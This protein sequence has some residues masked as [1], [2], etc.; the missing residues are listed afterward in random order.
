MDTIPEDCIVLEIRGEF[1]HFRKPSTTSPAQT[2][3]IPPRTTI[4]GMLAG[5]M[6]MERHSYYELFNRENSSIAVSLETSLRRLSLGIN[7][8]T[9]EG[10]SRSL[11][12]GRPGIHITDS[13]QQ[14]VFEVVCDPIY[15]V[16]VSLE[17]ETV[18]DRM[19]TLLSSGKSVYT[20]SLGLS[21]HL[22]TYE[23]IGRFDVTKESGSASIRSAVPG[24][25]IDL[26]PSPE[27]RY[28]TERSPAFLKMREE[29][30]RQAD[31][32]QTLTYDRNGGPLALRD[33][34]YA[35]INEDCVI[36]S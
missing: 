27:A 2:F 30:G 32:S 7:I 36:F 15:R 20:L 25:N 31:G 9:T 33:T 6:G 29:G 13:R 19:E 34:Q 3:G 16:Y 22:G 35:V 1:G 8:L 14:T 23:Y 5:I 11:K 28:V 12:S 17:D 10:S 21:E 24:E 18:M 4:A 26:I